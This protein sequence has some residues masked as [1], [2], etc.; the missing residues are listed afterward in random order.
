MS[1]FVEQLKRLHVVKNA[2]ENQQKRSRSMDIP[3]TNKLEA[4][5]EAEKNNT[6]SE[7]GT[8]SLEI[9][10]NIVK[11][12]KELDWVSN[13]KEEWTFLTIKNV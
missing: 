12:Y 5:L 1:N 7:F 2:F 11:L 4:F 9:H 3:E 13:E 6:F 8:S 10:N